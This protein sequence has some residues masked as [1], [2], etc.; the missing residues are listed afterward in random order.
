ME[1]DSGCSRHITSNKSSF[2]SIVEYNEGRVTFGDNATTKICDKGIIDCVVMSNF[3]NV[4]YIMGLKENLI[5][6]SQLCNEDYRVDFSKL[7]CMVI[8]KNGEI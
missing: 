6:I 4:W 1:L 7:A 3:E 8:D 2:T 5:S